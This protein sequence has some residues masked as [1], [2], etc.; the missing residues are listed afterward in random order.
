MLEGI[1]LADI[2]GSGTHDHGELALPVELL[3]HRAV[4]LNGLIRADDRGARLAEQHG[5]GRELLVGIKGA[6]G[7]LDMLDVVE[8]DTDNLARAQR[9]V[10]ARI[11]QRRGGA[12][13]PGA[14]SCSGAHLRME[15]L[16]GC[17]VVDQL[18]GNVDSAGECRAQVNDGVAVD[19]E[20][21]AGIGLCRSAV[22]D[23]THAISPDV[24]W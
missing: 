2:A 1:G 20:A 9:C 11:G 22:S 24:G 12:C 17:D 16:A 18:H 10:Q 15:C 3:G 23:E 21:D 13:C 7:L 14:R 19:D 4:V 5:A 6:A 8:T